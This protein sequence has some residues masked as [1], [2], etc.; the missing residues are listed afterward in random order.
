MELQHL[1]ERTSSAIN[2]AYAAGRADQRKA[3]I[4]I[5]KRVAEAGGY[6]MEGAD[7][8]DFQRFEGMSI[9]GFAIAKAIEDQTD[10][11][12]SPPHAA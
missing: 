8:G 12:T 4:A 6:N 7:G 3:D 9:A 1:F 2:A 11:A 5:A 10:P